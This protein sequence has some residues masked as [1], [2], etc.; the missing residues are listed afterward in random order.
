MTGISRRSL[1]SLRK[2]ATW[3]VISSFS[4]TQGPAITKKGPFSSMVKG[5]MRIDATISPS[6]MVILRPREA[7]DY[8]H[9]S[10][11]T[12][13]ALRISDTILERVEGS[14]EGFL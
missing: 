7:D 6:Q 14:Q 8:K 11:I 4:I 12:C 3:R 1:V 13:V 9:Q 10:V 5:P 2:P